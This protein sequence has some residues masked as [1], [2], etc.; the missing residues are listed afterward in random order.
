SLWHLDFMW[1]LDGVEKAYTE[2]GLKFQGV[3]TRNE[4]AKIVGK[5]DFS[6]H[7]YLED[8]K[9]L[10]SINSECVIA[11]TKFLSAIHLLYEYTK[12]HYLE[13][14]ESI[15]P[16]KQELYDDIVQAYQKEFQAFYDLGCRSI[17]MDE[18]VWAVLCDKEYRE[19]AESNG[20]DV[21][22]LIEEYI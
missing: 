2:S 5:I 15:Y 16:N 14:T 13:N 18:V 19:K 17:Q 8:Y 1:G 10:T 11:R 20:V 22:A 12:P 21:D 9:S 7:P 3:E 4:T 6:N